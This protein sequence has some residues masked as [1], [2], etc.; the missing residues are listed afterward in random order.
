[1]A[2]DRFVRQGDARDLADRLRALRP[3]YQTQRRELSAKRAATVLG[4]A[5]H[6][7]TRVSQALQLLRPAETM[8]ASAALS[9]R[10][11]ALDQVNTLN[12]LP[13]Q[14][15]AGRVQAEYAPLALSAAAQTAQPVEALH[16]ERAMIQWHLAR[17]QYVQAVGLGREWLVTWM[18]LHAGFDDPLDKTTRDETERVITTAN[19][20]RQAQSGSLGDRGFSTGRTLRKISQAA[21][22]LDLY[23]TLGELRNDIMHAG[24]RRSP[25]TA[26]DLAERVAK[27]CRRLDELPLP[28]Q[29]DAG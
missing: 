18:L 20:E 25:G 19:K 28:L 8:D 2:A 9:T 13:F 10:I 27:Q 17:G 3:D 1:V 7:L 6:E 14:L 29:G 11:A 12:G 24:K 22:A 26:K 23:N 15:L 21:T 5:A 4:Q 16:I